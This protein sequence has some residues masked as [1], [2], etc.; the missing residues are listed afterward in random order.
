MY[1][2]VSKAIEN[3][4]QFYQNGLYKHVKTINNM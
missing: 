1:L 2:N 4:P 3:H